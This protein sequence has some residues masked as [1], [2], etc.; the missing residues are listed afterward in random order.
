MPLSQEP[1]A[2]AYN[3]LDLRL[4]GGIP[5]HGGDVCEFLIIPDRA[6]REIGKSAYPRR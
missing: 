2:A 1:V 5:R 4:L 6:R 3:L